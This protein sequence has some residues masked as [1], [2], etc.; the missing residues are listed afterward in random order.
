MNKNELLAAVAKDTGI[1]K[2]D[3]E[4]VLKSLTA[5]IHAELQKPDGKVQIPDLGSFKSS[6]RAARTVRNPRTGESI[7]SPAC[8]VVK[9]T[10]AKAFK[11]AVNR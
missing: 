3:I 7:E 6:E 8:K 2:K 9:F 11:D 4:A 10:A 5:T 1:T